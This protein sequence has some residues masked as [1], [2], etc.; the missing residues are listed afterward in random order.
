MALVG[1]ASL[2]FLLCV[3]IGFWSFT[4]DR[5]EQSL[6]NSLNERSLELREM[7]AELDKAHAAL[8]RLSMRLNPGLHRLE[9]DR[10]IL[11]GG[12]A[13]RSTVFTPLQ[14]GVKEGYRY[15][16]TVRDDTGEAMLPELSLVLFDRLGDEVGRPEVGGQ[17]V[18]SLPSGGGR[19]YSGVIRGPRVVETR[20]FRVE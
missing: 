12:G 7:T 16:L 5:T 2:I 17:L 4:D 14:N 9:L 13:L 3:A 6:R 19:S 8:E 1:S 15:R 11:L 20:F 10:P 18:A